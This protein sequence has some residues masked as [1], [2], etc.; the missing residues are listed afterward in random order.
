MTQLAPVRCSCGEPF[1]IKMPDAAGRTV[2]CPKCRKPHP[3]PVDW[4]LRFA[5]QE[6]PALPAIPTNGHVTPAVQIKTPKRTNRRRKFYILET[7]S[8]LL[9]FSPAILGVLWLLGVTGLFALL[10]LAGKET[11]TG[12]QIMQGDMQSILIIAGL[13]AIGVVVLSLVCILCAELI[14]LSLAIEE[15]TRR[16]AERS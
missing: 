11:E 14:D 13:S 3:I 5:V 6:T 12:V 10:A 15:N 9:R 8:F 16:T 1:Q 2:N 4:G 7:I